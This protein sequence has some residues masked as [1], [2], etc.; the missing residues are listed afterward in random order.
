MDKDIEK[1]QTGLS[2]SDA[3]TLLKA[4]AVLGWNISIRKGLVATL[5]AM[6]LPLSLIP[7]VRTLHDKLDRMQDAAAVT[8]S[9]EKVVEGIGKDRECTS[10]KCQGL[11][12]AGYFAGGS[13]PLVAA[14]ALPLSIM[15][16]T[17]TGPYSDAATVD[18]LQGKIDKV[19]D[20]GS[21]ARIVPHSIFKYDL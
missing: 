21:S 4:G 11:I 12:L 14:V 7:P 19:Q 17:H 5:D 10:P 1:Q 16:A 9:A 20:G 8:A 13:A 18:H 15:W 2:K 3:K 6:L